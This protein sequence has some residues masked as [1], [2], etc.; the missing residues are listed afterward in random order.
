MQRSRADEQAWRRFLT[1]C[2]ANGAGSIALLLLA[3]A[4]CIAAAL[5]LGL[6]YSAAAVCHLAVTVAFGAVLIGN[7]ASPAGLAS[8]LFVLAGG[9]LAI[10]AIAILLLQKLFD[11][12]DERLLD[13]WYTLLSGQVATEQSDRL[14]QDVLCGR[15]YTLQSPEPGRFEK[16]FESGALNEKQLL[17]G[18]IG[19]NYHAEYLPFLQRALRCPEPAVRAQAAAVFV[20]LKEKFRRR[21]HDV[22]RRD[23]AEDTADELLES[24]SIALDCAESGFLEP[25]DVQDAISFAR[26]ICAKAEAAAGPVAVAAA[27]VLQCRIVRLSGEDDA[28]LDRLLHQAHRLPADL[29]LQLARCLV[30]TGR[31][32]DVNLLFRHRYDA[33]FAIEGAGLDTAGAAG[34]WRC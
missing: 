25:A 19:L 1:S 32:S 4:A 21:F 2:K 9:P 5:Y 20:R 23:S 3:D 6:G 33:P 31:F 13:R 27:E 18:R 12:R 26:A 15:E 11:A 10:V 22:R 17:L 7:G 16:I 14:H 29:R 24:A 30:A 28:I 34:G 8:V